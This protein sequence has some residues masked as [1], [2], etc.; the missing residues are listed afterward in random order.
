M[1]WLRR[2]IEALTPYRDEYS[3]TRE[4]SRISVVS[5]P[6]S[7]D[8]ALLY[9]GYTYSRLRKDS[10]FTGSYWD[11]FLPLGCVSEAPRMLMI[12]L[13]GGT[14]AYQVESLFPRATLESV[15]IDR[16]MVDVARRFYP[17]M[18]SKVFIADGFDFVRSK[19]GSYDAILLDAYKDIDIPG[20]FLSN[21]FV[22]DA[23]A[24]LKPV[25]AMAINYAQT[26]L[27]AEQLRLY[28][29]KLSRLFNVYSIPVGG[30]SDNTMLVCGKGL[31]K[32]EIV[33]SAQRR[34][35]KSREAEAVLRSYRR[36]AAYGRQR[37]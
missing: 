28:A 33:R 4:S 16:D 3:I 12:G 17:G 10:V 19:R 21:G 15:E 11:L 30:F 14:V 27:R 1:D 37:P 7:G 8:R 29:K 23:F 13:G 6:R 35:P 5:N 18:K 24:A 22:E 34:M 32:G 36:M 25:G 20:K 26:Q 31:A 9:N 2:I